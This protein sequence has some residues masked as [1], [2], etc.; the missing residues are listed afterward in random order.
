[1]LFYFT[2]SLGLPRPKIDVSLVNLTRKFVDLIKSAPEGVVDL[3]EVA[4]LMGGRK[5][6]VYDITNVLYG[7][8][9]IQKRSRSL[10]QWV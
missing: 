10:V 1:M 2:E 3:N 5:R 4:K 8:R 9:L 7:I 6:R